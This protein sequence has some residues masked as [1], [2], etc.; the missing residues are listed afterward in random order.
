VKKTAIPID[1]ETLGLID[2]RLRSS[3]RFRS[4]SA[5]VRAAIRAY[6]ARDREERSRER[7]TR[8]IRENERLLN[9]QLR[10]LEKEQ[11]TA[12]AGGSFRPDEDPRG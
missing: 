2:R 10:V 3:R 11:A 9:R 5:L 7:E 12:R 8:V 4:R 1:E 6:A